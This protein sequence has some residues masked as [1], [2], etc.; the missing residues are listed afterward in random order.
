MCSVPRVTFPDDVSGLA[1]AASSISLFS[2]NSVVIRRFPQWTFIND[3][4]KT[5][6]SYDSWSLQSIDVTFETKSRNTRIEGVDCLHVLDSLT[7]VH[8]D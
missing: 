8:D 5:N 4:N 6:Q 7:E 2:E 1:S 3:N